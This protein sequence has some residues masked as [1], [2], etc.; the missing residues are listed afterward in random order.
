M[1]RSTL[2]AISLLV[3]GALIPR[4][5]A[6][7]DPA[8][9]EAA[10]Q[11][12]TDLLFSVTGLAGPEAVR[13][14]PEQ[15][16]YFV[17]SFGESASDP[18]DA[19]GFIS[20]ISA[21]D[22]AMESLRFMTGTEASPLHMP[23]GMFIRGDTLWV[24][25][26][27]GVHGFLRTSG[28][29]AAFLDFTA[30]EPG[31]LN[32]IAVGPDGLLYVTDT[33]E[34]R[35]YRVGADGV[36]E[37]AIEDARTGPPNGITWDAA[38]AAFLL[39]PWGGETTLRAWDPTSGEIRDVTTLEGGRFDGIEIVGDGV[40]IASQDDSTL[41]W[42]EGE[43]ARPLI[44]VPGRPADIGIDTRRGRVAVPYI[45]LNRVDVWRLPAARAGQT[46]EELG[47]MTGCWKGELENGAA[48]E[49]IYTA[50]STNLILGISRYMRD[51]RAVQYE[52]SRITAD[53]TGIELLPF[54]GGNP[55]EHAFRLT[56]LRGDAATFE[57]P[58]HDFPKRI[59]YSR[60]PDGSLTARVD[61]G[62]ED[63]RAQEWR[64]MPVRCRP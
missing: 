19:N 36:P 34:G 53:S 14:D 37:V 47:F 27:D 30:L 17:A 10:V 46:L 58:E 51:G 12:S 44:R 38:R 29:H 49:E 5:A 42:L 11:D 35:V 45:A 60:A 41:H 16:V 25:D 13:Y 61:G 3:L 24:A 64:M 18:R 50:P 23:R 9:N 28:H 39:A 6:A 20:R 40:L 4:P 52:F 57:A 22:G 63:P 62:T 15:D 31:F 55:S 43:V 54:P 32:D 56:A 59:R 8:A 7:Q 2:C 21:A 33:G 48:L 26:V 1:H